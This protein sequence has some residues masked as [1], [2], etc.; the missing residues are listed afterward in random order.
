MNVCTCTCIVYVYMFRCRIIVF[1]AY[2]PLGIEVNTPEGGMSAHAV[3]LLV[4][5]DL[6]AQAKLLNMKQYNRA[7]GCHACEDK[8]VPRCGCPTARDWPCV[9]PRSPS[10]THQSVISNA[11][12][13]THGNSV[14][15][16]MITP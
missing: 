7:Y 2:H 12:E 9:I 15:S 10:S 11:Q 14:V 8:G 5:V 16:I 3:L 1:S 4:C 13:A 6:P